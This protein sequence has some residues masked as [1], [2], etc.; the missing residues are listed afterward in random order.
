MSQVRMR[1][2]RGEPNRDL[3]GFPLARA[4]RHLKKNG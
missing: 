2:E 1:K 3:P 4:E